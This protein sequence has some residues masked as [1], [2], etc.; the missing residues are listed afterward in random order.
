MSKSVGNAIAP[1]DVIKESGAEILRLWVAMSEYTEELRVSKEILT[2]VIDVYRKLRNT[3]RILAANLYDFN[4]ATDLVPIEQLDGIDRY[5]LAWY[6]DVGQRVKAAYDVYYFADATKLLNQLA[7]VDL[8]AFYVDVTKDRMY[9][10]APNSP[11]RRSTQTVMY[12]ICEGLAKLLAPILP[13]TADTLWLHLPGR[14]SASVHLESFPDLEA[15]ID[16]DLIGR[17]ERLRV[18]REQ[19]NAALEDKRKDKVIGTALGVRAVI[20]ASG[21]I[22]TLLEA[23]LDL[24]PM[25][26]IVSD[27]ALHVGSR[28]GADNVHVDIE[29]APGIKCERCWRFVPAVRTEPQWTGICDRCVDALGEPA[30]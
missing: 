2:R 18:V 10:L 24:L 1:Q 8:S 20:T 29:K 25:L 15:L 3:V 5:A 22:A 4:P 6:A 9:T 21:P 14:R 7:T 23:H 26:F 16:R 27:V 11:E 12:L 17:W 19:V 13:V 30:A 28:D